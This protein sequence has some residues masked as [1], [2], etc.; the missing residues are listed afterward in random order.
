MESKINKKII[1]IEHKKRIGVGRVKE[2]YKSGAE[3]MKSG[4]KE[5]KRVEGLKE[6]VRQEKSARGTRL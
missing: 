6:G 2:E 4:K 3:G 5:K 1:E